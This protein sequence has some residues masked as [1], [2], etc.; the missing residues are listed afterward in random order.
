MQIQD[1]ESV[2]STTVRRKLSR[3]ALFAVGGG[4]LLAGGAGWGLSRILGA[5]DPVTPSAAAVQDAETARRR[6]GVVV[7]RELRAAPAV[8][9]LGGRT[10][11]T[12]AYDNSLPGKT[13]RVQA[14]DELQVRLTNALP[15]P[16]TVHW[17]GLALRNDMDG[18]PGLTMAEVSAGGSFD[19]RFVVPDPGTYWFHPHVGVQ[20]DTGLSAPLIVE[21]PHETGSYDDEAVLT[22]DDWT[23][24]WAAAPADILENARQSGMGGMDMSGG[25]MDMG[26]MTSAAEPLGS[27]TGDVTYPAHLINGRL[28]LDPFTLRVTP[29]RRVRLRVINAGSDT[30]YRFAVGGH[31][32]TVTH[33]DGYP[34]VPVEVDTIILGMGERY[35]CVITV[36]DGQFPIVAV[37]E[38]KDDPSAV[39]VLRSGSGADVT[40][41]ARPTELTG[42]L[43]KYADLVA[44]DASRLETRSPDRELTMKLSM[45]DGGRRW[46]INNKTFD[47]HQPFEIEAGER[48]KITMINQSMMFHPMHLHGHTFALTTPT[49]SG[50]RKDTVNVVPM[51]RLDIELQAD[52]PG[53]WLVHC[54][55]IYHAELGMMS[56]ISYV[57]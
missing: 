1:S 28:P 31:R 30:A 50:P 19:Y 48:V 54:H 51:Q 37:P 5:S 26:G 53:Q 55:N 43:L 33:T 25:G 44:T 45:A 29:G 18:V 52:N 12:W 11:S 8:I 38:G 16:T 22:L 13:I 42:Q 32:L 23:D 15:D 24:G 3:R 36:K 35:D 14:G 20:L 17:H 6:T 41:N 56:T 10:V 49:G 34:V 57:T 21:D 9:D 39:A 2:R 40:A 7:R 27:D 4:G 47:D 46:L